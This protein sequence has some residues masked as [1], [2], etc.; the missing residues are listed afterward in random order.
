[1][2]PPGNTGVSHPS[3]SVWNLLMWMTS[4]ID[5]PVAI[6]AERDD[7]G[8]ILSANGSPCGIRN[9]ANFEPADRGEALEVGGEV[10][11]GATGN[12][13]SC[14]CECAQ[15]IGHGTRSVRPCGVGFIEDEE[16]A[17]H[18]GCNDS[19]KEF[20]ACQIYSTMTSPCL[21]LDRYGLWN[22]HRRR[23]NEPC[24]WRFMLSALRRLFCQVQ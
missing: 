24:S 17:H 20:L 13:A 16:A 9:N 11:V 21:V 19:G 2:A 3:C 12:H 22:F 18:Q 7:R 6:D 8:E 15:R 10:S 23:R 4:C 1:M 5:C 14:C